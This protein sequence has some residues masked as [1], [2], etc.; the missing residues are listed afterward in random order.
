M[1]QQLSTAVRD[2]KQF[3]ENYFSNQQSSNNGKPVDQALSMK[4][5]GIAVQARAKTIITQIDEELN[6]HGDTRKSVLLLFEAG[7]R[8]PAKGRKTRSDVRRRVERARRGVLAQRGRS[9]S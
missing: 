6:A 1:E 7:R 8:R 5:R 2:L 4:T 9:A 3:H